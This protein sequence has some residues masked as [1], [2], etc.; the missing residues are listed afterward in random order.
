VSAVTAESVAT[1]PVEFP[2]MGRV[3]I[4]EDHSKNLQ[5]YSA[6]LLRQGY[7]VRACAS[8]SEA[9]R[10]LE[11]ESFDFIVLSQRHSGREGRALLKRATE[12]YG[13]S[14]VLVL[15]HAADRGNYPDSTLMA[16]LEYFHAPLAA[17]ILW[18]VNSRS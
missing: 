11:S 4:V 10:F 8:F 3:L 15:G 18:L 1:A 14:P 6:G 9:L 5:V 12:M 2:P 17:E 7:A 16:G 13:Y